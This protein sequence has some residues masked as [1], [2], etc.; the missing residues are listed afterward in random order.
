MS[1]SSTT[2]IYRCSCPTST[3]FCPFCNIQFQSRVRSV[4]CDLHGSVGFMTEIRCKGCG[5]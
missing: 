4:N 1:T 2:G 3:F 5:F